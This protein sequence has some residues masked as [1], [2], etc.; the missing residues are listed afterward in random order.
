M[1]INWSVVT[2]RYSPTITAAQLAEL[3]A[4][5]RVDAGADAPVAAR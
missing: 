1:I 5:Y 3:L 4:P 2:R